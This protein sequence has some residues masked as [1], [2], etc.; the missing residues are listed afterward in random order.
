MFHEKKKVQRFR[1]N[2]LNNFFW[3]KNFIANTL[4]AN[5]YKMYECDKNQMTYYNVKL[6]KKSTFEIFEPLIEHGPHLINFIILTFISENNRY[7]RDLHK[8]WTKLFHLT[9]E[10]KVKCKTNYGK[11][12]KKSEFGNP[13]N[14][15]LCF[16]RGTLI[17]LGP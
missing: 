15:S 5:V 8:I 12:E 9:W 16:K 2:N 3:R 10:K 6:F 11:N 7:L 17:M 14:E 4:C 1:K 13:K